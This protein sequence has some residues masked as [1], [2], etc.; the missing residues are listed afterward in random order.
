M[1]KRKLNFQNHVYGHDLEGWEGF[2]YG[3]DIVSNERLR[4]IK[5]NI[6]LI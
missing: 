4:R 3:I 5:E 2:R 1:S 6:K